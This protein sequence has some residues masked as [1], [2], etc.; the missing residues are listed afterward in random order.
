M[1]KENFLIDLFAGLSNKGIQ[2]FVFGEYQ[3]LPHDTGGSDID[4][5]IEK[6]ENKQDVDKLV[7]LLTSDNNICIASFF[8]NSYALYYRIQTCTWGV[9][10]DF[11]FGGFKYKG[12]EYYPFQLLD[13][14][15]IDHNNI[16]VLNIRKGYY[17]DFYKEIIHN[18]K[19]KEKYIKGFIEEIESNVLF[20]KEEVLN[21]Y[22]EKTQKCIFNNLS[23]DGLKRKSKELQKLIIRKVSKG[24]RLQI[25]KEKIF[26]LKRLVTTRPGY[27]I[28]VEGTDGAGKSAV[29]NKITPILNEGFHHGVIYCH[30]RP[31][32]I[33]DLGVL[34]GKRNSCEAN[35]VC[36]TPHENK[37]SGFI[38]SIVRWLYY[39]MDY[40]LGYTIKV[41]PQIHKRS[42]VFIFDR[43]YYD[44]YIDAKRLR[45]R[46]PGKILRFGEMFISKPDLILCLGGDPHIIFSRKPETSLEEVQRQ[47]KD[48]KSFCDS[49]RNTVWVDTTCDID[50]TINK[51]MSAI[52]NMMRKRGFSKCLKC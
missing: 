35:I 10:L 17:L 44:Y 37:P 36:T 27:V 24:N 28:A 42:F 47:I 46:L 20:Y 52:V 23:Y 4:I 1:F 11:L 41:W 25:Y 51:T 48:L 39:L 18:G 15:I 7:R 5:L 34:F 32:F 6:E 14:N 30:L 29:I 45:V 50:Q 21:L 38:G 33:P 12:T 19:A 2:Y 43:Y 3:Y 22:G 8:Y 40:T 13:G 9:Q 31:R 26:L 16:K 49:R